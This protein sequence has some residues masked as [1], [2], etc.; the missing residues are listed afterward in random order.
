MNIEQL[1]DCS[2]AELEAMTDEQLL[3]HFKPYFNVTRPEFAPKPKSPTFKPTPVVQ[4]K[5]FGAKLE[6]LKAMG[7]DLS[8]LKDAGKR[9]K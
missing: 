3:E 6:Q 1:L 7:L 4:T 8:Y 5:A 9:K 2:A